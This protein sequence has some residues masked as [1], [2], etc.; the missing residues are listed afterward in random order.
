MI[1]IRR[2]KPDEAPAAKRVVYRVA[3]EIFKDQRTLE[4]S[5]SYHE[6]RGELKDMDNIQK[7]Y[8]ENGG[9]FLVLEDEAQIIGT[10]AIRQLQG[11]ICELKRLWLLTEY[12]GRGLGYRMLQELLAVAREMGYERIRLETDA[13]FQKRA[14]EFY[15]K[16][17][18]YEIPIPNAT[19][20]EDILMELSL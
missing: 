19:A 3:H 2:I 17:G 8:L 15:K 13:V 18:F 9:I 10:G 4:E 14:V 16:L 20:A 11:N 7:N 1:N 12:H 6:L 5:V